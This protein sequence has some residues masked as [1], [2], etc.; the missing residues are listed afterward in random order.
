MSREIIPPFGNDGMPREAAFALS[1]P[2]VNERD[3]VTMTDTGTEAMLTQPREVMAAVVSFLPHNVETPMAAFFIN[4]GSATPLKEATALAGAY[5]LLL[6]GRERLKRTLMSH[7][8][9]RAAV[10]STMRKAIDRVSSSDDK[11]FAA[12]WLSGKDTEEA[13]I[14][15]SIRN[16]LAIDLPREAHG[17]FETADI[18]SPT[19]TPAV[20]RID[21]MDASLQLGMSHGALFMPPYNLIV[22]LANAHPKINGRILPGDRQLMNDLHIEA[23]RAAAPNN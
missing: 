17:Q 12:F 10:A 16:V 13:S 3:Y 7:P 6:G 2:F 8:M 22:E 4:P 15:F 20:V 5:K 11:T 19:G 9:G 23:L 1:A 14:G 18:G 21:A